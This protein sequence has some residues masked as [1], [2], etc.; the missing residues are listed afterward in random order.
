MLIQINSL[1]MLFAAASAVAPGKGAPPASKAPAQLLVNNTR[2]TPVE[3]F[4]DRGP[5]DQRLGSVPAHAQVSLALPRYLADGEDAT[6]FIHPQKGEDL[7]AQDVVVKKHGDIDVLVPQD[8][9]GYLPPPPPPMIAN[10]GIGTTT[11]TVENHRAHAVDVYVQYGAFDQRLGIVAPDKKATMEVPAW[12]AR[13]RQ[14]VQLV[15]HPQEGQDLASSILPLHK[16]A[17]LLVKVPK[18]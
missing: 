6:I 16:G 9:S 18:P 13:E 17:H 14:D 10:P 12:L 1:A 3:V 15:I 11:V 4:L 8:A 5:L 2:N 7:E